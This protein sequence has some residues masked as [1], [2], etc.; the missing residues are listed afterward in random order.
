[1][2]RH[3]R[4]THPDLSVDVV[5]LTTPDALTDANGSQE[6]G[7]P[8]QMESDLSSSSDRSENLDWSN[9][10]Q[11]KKTIPNLQD[12]SVKGSPKSK[13]ERFKR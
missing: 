13:W 4:K 9:A 11:L 10:S 3:C 2:R 5:L 6:C 8:E 12:T 1:M 7:V